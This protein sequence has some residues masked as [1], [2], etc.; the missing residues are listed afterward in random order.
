[1]G[2]SELSG[3][4]LIQPCRSPWPSTS[5]SLDLQLFPAPSFLPSDSAL[6]RTPYWTLLMLNTGSGLGSACLTHILPVPA[7][8]LPLAPLFAPPESPAGAS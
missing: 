2:F 7:V 5:A 3:P 8:D 6:S 1:M 4:A